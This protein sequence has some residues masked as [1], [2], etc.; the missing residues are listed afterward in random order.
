TD[1]VYLYEN[2]GST[3]EVTVQKNS[4]TGPWKRYY[5]F[6][7]NLNFK[8]TNENV[9]T[10]IAPED[11]VGFQDL[12]V[13]YE[14]TYPDDDKY[15]CQFPPSSCSG[16]L[17]CD[18][19]CMAEFLDNTHPYSDGT[20][21]NDY[22]YFQYQIT[23]FDQDI[24]SMSSGEIYTLGTSSDPG[25]PGDYLK[26]VTRYRE[27]CYEEP[28]YHDVQFRR[29]INYWR[30]CDNNN[31]LNMVIIKLDSYDI[32]CDGAWR[33]LVYYKDYPYDDFYA[34]DEAY[35]R[36]KE[37]Y[38]TD[39]T[40]YYPMQAKGN[41]Y[42]YID[43]IKNPGTSTEEPPA[44]PSD[45]DATAIA[46]DQI[47]LTWTDNSDNESGFEIERTTD[48][49]TFTVSANTTSYTDTN[50]NENTT[51]SYR[52]RAYNDAGYSDYSNEASAT[53]PTCDSEAPEA[54]SGLT[55]K[56]PGRAPKVVLEWN[57]NSTNED[58]FKIYRDG[59]HY[60]TVGSNTTS[61]ED[62]NISSGEK[63]T[64]QVCAYNDYGESCSDT[65]S[66]TTK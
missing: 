63:Y 65:V 52:V 55:A 59:T 12:P 14:V 58:G 47:E 66:I 29:S 22:Q 57:D 8:L 34:G 62:N 36:V 17:N 60:A 53:T 35:L 46:C 19:G 27:G 50:L 41:F 43:F 21:E 13:L 40:W 37:R 26:I 25:E 7:Y 24:E 10:G 11:Y 48:G 23:V 3:I 38:C 31:A 51:Y 49:Q 9:G 64:Y 18:A 44:A 20:A 30:A 4:I 42:F 16:C 32:E 45:L 61:Y 39:S 1:G 6:A 33:M 54:P 15:C 5:D 28:T 56:Q 2:N